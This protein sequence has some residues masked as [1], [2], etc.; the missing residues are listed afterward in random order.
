MIQFLSLSALLS[1]TTETSIVNAIIYIIK[2]TPNVL[3]LEVAL[4]LNK[5]D[6]TS[7]MDAMC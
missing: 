1:I 6:F 4:H 5:L 2:R 3:S 7:T